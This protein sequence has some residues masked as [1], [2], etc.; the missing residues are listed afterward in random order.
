MF[1]MD[2]SYVV[3]L[4]LLTNELSAKVRFKAKVFKD[5]FKIKRL[6]KFKFDLCTGIDDLINLHQS[7]L[8]KYVINKSFGECYIQ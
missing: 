4:F 1:V 3:I 7:T 2:K 8:P 5:P 6:A